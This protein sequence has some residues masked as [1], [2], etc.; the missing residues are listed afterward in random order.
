[1]IKKEGI[2]MMRD[3]VSTIGN[4]IDKQS[5]AYLGSV[6]GEGFPNVKAMLAPRVREGIKT[7]YLTTN[8]SSRRVAQFRENP[9]A[10]LYFCDRRFFRGVM[11]K[12]SVEV[13]EDPA[14]KAL[15]W[16]EGD[17]MYYPEGVN[18][19]D[20]CVLRFTASA[21]RYYSNFKSEDFVIG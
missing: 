20:Y 16:R 9:R 15:I 6:D 19:P 13:L 1:M 4:L 18:D 11:L 5:T 12:G 3:P 14:A 8:T 10:C 21:G 17:T 2:W 7:F